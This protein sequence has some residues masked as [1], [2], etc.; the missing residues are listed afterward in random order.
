[1]GRSSVDATNASLI[2]W[3]RAARCF[4]V[5]GLTCF[6]CPRG[7]VA[8]FFAAV[9]DFFFGE[10]VVVFEDDFAA[11]PLEVPFFAVAGAGWVVSAPAVF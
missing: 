11:V 3:A 8:D 4:L 7:V 5:A 1:M 10:V 6:L 9:V 2:R